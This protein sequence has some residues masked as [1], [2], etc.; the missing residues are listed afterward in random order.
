MD[1]TQ[2]H[3][4]YDLLTTQPIA[5]LGTLHA[6]EPFVSMAPFAIVP[7]GGGFVIHVSRLATHT[8]DM[9]ASPKVSLLV[10]APL[11]PDVPPQ[12][13][14]RITIQGQAK[15]CVEPNPLHEDAKAAYL[16][17]F[18]E[19]APMFGFADFSLFVVEPASAR[20]VGGFAQATSLSAETLKRIL[21][22]G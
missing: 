9:I 4:L 17:R 1:D 16:A 15:Q 2:S 18:P 12:A 22:A 10:T 11:T 5:A 14:A 6:G 8:K 3:A 7:D 21:S 19:S 20:F 13:V